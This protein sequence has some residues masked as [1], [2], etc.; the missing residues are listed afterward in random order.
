MISPDQAG[1]A[2]M[3]RTERKAGRYS[4]GR[5]KRK[6]DLTWCLCLTLHQLLRNWGGC[7]AFGPEHPRNELLFLFFTTPD[8]TTLSSL[9]RIQY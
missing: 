6:R 3:R 1:R 4:W 8:P 2:G 9:P 5:Q 7:S